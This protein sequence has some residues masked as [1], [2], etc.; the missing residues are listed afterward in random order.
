MVRT[1]LRASSLPAESGLGLLVGWVVDFVE[2]R[3]EDG[4]IEITLSILV[5]Y[6]VYLAAKEAHAS[7]VLA[8]VVCGL[9]LSRRS[10]NFF[11]PSVRLQIGSGWESLNFV[12]NGLVFVLIG[13]QL[14]SIRASIRGYSL[15]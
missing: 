2:R 15:A 10:V 12:L 13:L 1:A 7:G 3:I 14:P 8:V 4:P 9:F 11:S 6:A 5:P